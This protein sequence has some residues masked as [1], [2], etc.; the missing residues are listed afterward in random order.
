MAGVA[1]ALDLVRCET[2]QPQSA[3]NAVDAM[4]ENRSSPVATQAIFDRVA[5]N[6]ATDSNF[7][8][9]VSNT[10]SCLA[11]TAADPLLRGQAAYV[12]GLLQQST[13][14]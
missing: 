5:S 7:Y 11:N 4:Y 1:D 6:A 8:N 12:G 3:R 14:Q 2:G 10:L 9:G 13:G